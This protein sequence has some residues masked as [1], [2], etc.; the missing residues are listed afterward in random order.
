MRSE[1]DDLSRRIS[2]EE[3]KKELIAFARELGFRFVPCCSL[4]SPAPC[5]RVSR[6]AAGRVRREKCITWS[7]AKRNVAIQRFYRA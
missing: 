5:N 3:L 7:A 2:G 6:L 1:V 4:R